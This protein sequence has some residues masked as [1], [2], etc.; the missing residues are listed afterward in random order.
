MFCPDCG[1]RAGEQA[2]FCEK[3]GHTLRESV[4]TPE[5][6]Q[7]P[8]QTTPGREVSRSFRRNS[9]VYTHKSAVA[10]ATKANQWLSEIQPRNVWLSISQ[11][12]GY[13]TILTLR[14]ETSPG[15]PGRRFGVSYVAVPHAR[16]IFRGGHAD[17]GANEWRAQNPYARVVTERPLSYAG[18][19]RE[20]WILWQT[21]N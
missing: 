6:A 20:L 21:T 19:I 17:T 9:F 11:N 5:R 15:S 10:L 18:L 8:R 1:H 14:C 12:H 13:A 3:C 4:A 16:N 2:Q 7:R